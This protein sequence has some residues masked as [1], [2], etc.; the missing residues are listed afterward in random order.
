MQSCTRLVSM[1]DGA[2]GEGSAGA[3]MRWLRV[4]V[5]G[6]GWVRSREGWMEETEKDSEGRKQR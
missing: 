5:L 4:R 3:V 6:A 1:A 2:G